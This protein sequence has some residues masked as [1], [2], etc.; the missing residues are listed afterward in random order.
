M[1][2]FNYKAKLHL[3]LQLHLAYKGNMNAPMWTGPQFSKCQTNIHILLRRP[4][5]S[6]P[7]FMFLVFILHFLNTMLEPVHLV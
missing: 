4:L 1:H 3:Q 6:P 5:L 2:H 7:A